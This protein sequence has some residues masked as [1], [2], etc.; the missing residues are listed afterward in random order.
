V[1]LAEQDRG[2]WR[3]AEVDEGM[4]MLRRAAAAARTPGPYTVQAAI[5]AEHMRAATADE[6]DW[7]AIARLYVLLERLTGSPVVRLNRAVAVAEAEGAAAGL[8][9]LDGLEELLPRHHRL[10]ATR[11]ELLRRTGDRKGAIAE[12]DRAIEQVGTVAERAYLASRRDELTG[13]G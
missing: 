7:A 4:A 3:R 10:P 13:D 12:Y 6:T 9:L 11:A 8:A 2:R 1:P 5:A